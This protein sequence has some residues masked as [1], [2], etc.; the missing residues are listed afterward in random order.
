MKFHMPM[1][2]DPFFIRSGNLTKCFFCQHLDIMHSIT[3][4][5]K[6][7]FTFLHDL[8]AH[9][10][11]SA[12]RIA[13]NSKVRLPTTLFLSSASTKTEELIHTIRQVSFPSLFHLRSVRLLCVHTARRVQSPSRTA[14]DRRPPIIS[15]KYA[16]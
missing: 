10:I 3:I 9:S 11:C 4:Y 15:I 7:N 5:T 14:S 12:I 6:Y 8:A 2:T 1:T 16:A 13:H